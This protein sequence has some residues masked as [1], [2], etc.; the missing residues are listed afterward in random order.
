V[1]RF[2]NMQVFA[3]VV[4]SGSFAAAAARLGISASMVSQH[5]KDLEERLG[6]RLLNRT[7]R[8]VSLT[9]TGRAYYERCAGLLAELEEIERAVSD[10]HSA[11]R[12]ELRVNSSPTFGILHL[13]PAVADF[14]ARYSEISVELMLSDHMADMIEERFDVAVQI[15]QLPDSS[16]IARQLA[17]CRLV[18]CGA[19]DY[20]ARHGIPHAPADLATHNCLT[21]VTGISYYRTWHLVAADGTALNITPIGNLR[22]NSA[23]ALKVAALAGQGVAYLPTYLVGDALQSGALVTVL[24]DYLAPPLPVRAVYPHNR[25]L[26]AKVRVFVDFLAARF[27]HEPPWDNWERAQGDAAVIAAV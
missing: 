6:V 9:E 17:L 24:D 7:T 13:A 15:G 1:D 14:T 26:S 11:P 18:V 22:T 3:K 21:I 20:F 10:M 23:A 25:H 2:D 4:E 12:G 16:L 19:P 5:V 8:K 27:G